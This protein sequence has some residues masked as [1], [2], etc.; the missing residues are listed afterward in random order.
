MKLAPGRRADNDDATVMDPPAADDARRAA[1]APGEAGPGDFRWVRWVFLRA[2]AAIYL[3][4]FLSFAVQA[5]GLIGPQGILPAAAWLR[6][7]RSQIGG[8][9]WRE[10]PTLG[11]WFPKDGGV[12]ELCWAGAVLAGLLFLNLAPTV[13]LAGLWAAYLSLCVLGQDF[14]SFQWDTL[15]LET[16]FLAI[17]VAPRHWRPRLPAAET[18]V[19]APMVWLQ[20]WLLFRLM[21]LS[22]AVKLLSGDPLWRNLTALTVHYETQPLP[23]WLGWWAH[24]LP[25]WAHQCS[26]AAMFGI[27]LLGPWLIVC[28]RR[29]RLAAAGAFILLLSLIAVTGNYAFFDAL[30]AALCLWLLEDR[31]LLGMA[32]RVGLTT[33]TLGA[34]SAIPVVRSGWR[35]V[36]GRT[37]AGL[38]A[39]LIGAISLTETTGRLFGLRLPV[40]GAVA[41]WA[42][43]FRSVNSYGLF[44][45]MTPRRPEIVVEGSEDGAQWKAYEFRWKPGDLRRRPGFVEPHQPRLDWQLWFAALS[46][47]DR[48]PW[49]SQFLGAL[50]EGRP[51]VLDLLGSNPFPGR[52]PKFIRA[53]L[54]EYHFTDLAERRATGDWWKRERLGL[55]FPV[56]SL[57]AAPVEPSL[58]L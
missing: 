54:Y 29:A 1:T 56:S 34:R 39:A 11:W 40:A 51:A 38:A 50:L 16:G 46:R 13:C 52:P 4:A 43:P 20:R 21:F 28:G 36:L 7:L 14:L 22:G 2:L 10:L 57:R 37:G 24:Q 15:L 44:A 31:H 45:V 53:V 42:R 6:G 33:R 26:C 19:R 32:G 47:P 12:H 55:Y 35:D 3:D 49:F 58:R 5:D 27:E 25:G 8:A 23:T 9:A 48:E 30:S 17:W 41:E 18:P